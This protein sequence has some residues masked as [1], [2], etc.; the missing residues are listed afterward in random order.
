[1]KMTTITRKVGC[2]MVVDISG[3]IELGEESAALCDLVRD[4]SPTYAWSYADRHVWRLAQDSLPLRILRRATKGEA[5]H[6]RDG[7]A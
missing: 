7:T 1:M 5:A 2:V 3:R 4:G 6:G